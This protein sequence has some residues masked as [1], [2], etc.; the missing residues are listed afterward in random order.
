MRSH[1]FFSR[2][3]A[4]G[5]GCLIA[6]C[7]TFLVR[8]ADTPGID[9]DFN[10]AAVRAAVRGP[11]RS[12][13]RQ[14]DGKILVAGE[15]PT[16]FVRNAGD[17]EWLGCLVRLKPDGTLDDTFKPH[18]PVPQ[19]VPAGPVVSR[20]VSI[21]L[22]DPDGIGGP[23]HLVAVGQFVNLVGGGIQRLVRFRLSDG[24][25]DNGFTHFL[26]SE[27]TVVVVQ[28]SDQRIIVGGRAVLT[29][30]ILPPYPALLTRIE[31]AGGVDGSFRQVPMGANT[32]VEVDSLALQAD[33]SLLVGGVF[34]GF[35][36]STSTAEPVPVRNL[37]RIRANGILDTAFRPDPDGPVHSVVPDLSDGRILAGGSFLNIGRQPRLRVAT[38][39]AVTGMARHEFFPSGS[40]D[41]GRVDLY[42]LDNVVYSV[43]LQPDGKVLAGGRSLGAQGPGTPGRGRLLRLLPNGAVDQYFSPADNPV[44]PGFANNE[45]RTIL[46]FGSSVVDQA[47]LVAGT[48]ASVLGANVLRVL[49]PNPPV[50]LSSRLTVRVGPGWR[51]VS[52]PPGIDITATVTEQ[53][54][55]ADFSNTVRLRATPLA[56]QL[57][58]WSGDGSGR[59]LSRDVFMDGDQSVQLSSRAAVRLSLKVGFGGSVEI[60]GTPPPGGIAVP[61]E[62]LAGPVAPPPAEPNSYERILPAGTLLLFRA[63]PD[64]GNTVQWSG[65]LAGS[66]PNRVLT[67]TSDQIV[68]AQFVGDVR[69][70]TVVKSGTGG[71]LVSSIPPT[72]ESVPAMVCE[73]FVGA[74]SENYP[75]G[76]EVT[77]RAA[78]AFG[79]R[80]TGWSG[81]PFV[82]V[83]SATPPT[84]IRVTLDSE[85]TVTANFV[86]GVRLAVS[87]LP[88]GT[89]GSVEV[90][91]QSGALNT[92]VTT[93]TATT[94]FDALV[95]VPF[96]GQFY[97]LRA[98]PPPGVDVRW[99]EDGLSGTDP[100][101]RLVDLST[102]REVTVTYV[103]RPHT[104][105]LGVTGSGSIRFTGPMGG[106][107]A[108]SSGECVFQYP[109]E[110]EVALT[111]EPALGWEFVRWQDVIGDGPEA[112]A[113]PRRITTSATEVRSARALFAELVPLTVRLIGGGGGRVWSTLVNP[114]RSPG[115]DCS[116]TGGAGCVGRFPRGT[117][118]T[119]RAEANDGSE[120]LG[121]TDGSRE[122]ERPVTVNGPTDVSA[123]FVRVKRL[124]VT[125]EGPGSGLVKIVRQGFPIGTT[126][127]E[128]CAD[129]AVAE[130][131]VRTIA[132]G[133][134][135]ELK[136]FPALDTAVHWEGVFDPVPT[137]PNSIRVRMSEDRDITARFV[138]LHLLSVDLS[139]DGGGTVTSDPPGIRS[140]TLP[141]ARFEQGVVVTL[142]AHPVLGWR[143]ARWTGGE[144]A[145]APDRRT[146]V[147]SG[148]T[149][150][151]ATFER[152]PPTVP[153][154]EPAD[155][156]VLVGLGELSLLA[157]PS[158]AGPFQ[159]QWYRLLPGAT[160]PVEWG[161]PTDRPQLILPASDLLPEHEH[162]QI[163]VKVSN[164][165]G[166]A[167]SDWWTLR[168]ARDL[169][170]APA[171]FATRVADNG[172]RH[173]LWASEHPEHFLVALG[174]VDGDPDGLPS[175]L[176]DGDDRAPAGSDDEDG[177]QPEP[178]NPAAPGHFTVFAQGPGKLDAWIDFNGNGVWEE[179]G[180][181]IANHATGPDLS[182]GANDLRFDVPSGLAPGTRI[183]RFRF[184]STGV[185]SPVGEAVDGEVEDHPVEI[186]GNPIRGLAGAQT[187][188]RSAVATVLGVPLS[189]RRPFARLE[190]VVIS[191]S[192]AGGMFSMPPEVVDLGGSH[193]LSLPVRADVDGTAHL[194]V[195]VS[196]TEGSE[197]FV[198]PFQLNVL[199]AADVDGVADAVEDAGPN[200]GDGNLDSLLDARQSG[201]TSLPT[202][203]AGAPY[204]TVSSLFGRLVDVTTTLPPVPPPE[205]VE[206]P[207]GL[208]GFRLEGLRVS[209][210]E[211]PVTLRFQEDLPAGT[212]YY[213]LDPATSTYRE[214][215]WNPETPRL[216]GAEFV[217]SH[218][219][220]LHLVDG[221]VGDADGAADSVIVDPGGPTVNVTVG[222]VSL[223]LVLLPDG[224]AQL[225]WPM[226]SGIS[227]LQSTT[228]LELPSSWAPLPEVP[229]SEG[230]FYRLTVSPSTRAVFFRLEPVRPVGP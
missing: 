130:S 178:L 31:P 204:V 150:V 39:D 152:M 122:I 208:I 62:V 88:P 146:V 201:V 125:A 87:L 179:G 55:F 32:A 92:P 200:G 168:F 119:L 29:P 47:A 149:R 220:V 104:L 7:L 222:P 203:V 78:P 221:G 74:C 215:L 141:E 112:R 4:C 84:T 163:R 68:T 210:A 191:D 225:S 63:L 185:D 116:A 193:S 129:S 59:G 176:S 28:S 186:L 167:F 109:G 8:A 140:P 60:S 51:V 5:V 81:G 197:P 49:L 126:T 164:D 1:D 10:L 165:G 108:C 202:A 73:P 22:Q 113:N 89:P 71:G 26:P 166:F 138:P 181:R 66:D 230:G 77:L 65:A 69:R 177:V 13:V 207:M 156:P 36:E 218:T 23:D 86:A 229:V 214:F 124:T 91:L 67:L 3:V 50:L 228:T 90:R 98:V 216:P 121:W 143:I 106:L 159:F 169:G 153:P 52:D 6:G 118:V 194:E 172:A 93:V 94:P 54:G 12:M 227:V 45:V 174:R 133:N 135:V 61:T 158:G 24:A 198:A 160:D 148:P 182:A 142:T 57:P 173:L 136:A 151:S 44:V 155:V 188:L 17:P 79:S 11:I 134:I 114:P 58:V 209:G 100:N 211:V 183:G 40:D 213:K 42:E 15:F 34:D 157:S 56:T 128:L 147:L 175:D 196:V 161:P 70:L 139:A 37:A 30:G 131:C 217:D 154:L 184:S 206:F 96:L 212:R 137:D 144:D 21:A 224:R 110:T 111:A 226:A 199:A 187:V 20:I 33:G 123:T 120:F 64:S 2:F 25:V 48:N 189:V 162:T 43:A 41:P 180:E 75:V 35:K 145:G 223:S 80:F 82:A 19:P 205:G 16:P 27:P 219:I 102:D 95:D 115:I 99:S 190:V 170:D 195:R 107:E 103:V 38:V 105:L 132:D 9:P 76:T 85:R 14:P 127:Y 53:I 171:P 117:V 46:A 97:F 18:D 83:D 192:V 72:P 101:V